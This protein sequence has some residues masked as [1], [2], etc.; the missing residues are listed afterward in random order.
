[1]QRLE[2]EHL[3]Q[4]GIRVSTTTTKTS[5]V[6]LA[7]CGDLEWS[8]LVTP[9]LPVEADASHVYAIFAKKVSYFSCEKP[10]G[11]RQMEKQNGIVRF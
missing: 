6:T 2:G 9:H 10:E 5:R 4:W 3:G 1:M 7:G 11:S 8:F